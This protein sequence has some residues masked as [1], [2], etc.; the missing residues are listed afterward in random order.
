MYSSCLNLPFPDQFAPESSSPW[1][2]RPSCQ[3][4]ISASWTDSTLCFTRYPLSKLFPRRSPL[5]LFLQD[6]ITVD[7]IYYSL[8]SL[9]QTFFLF[10]AGLGWMLAM[11]GMYIGGAA[12]YA[13][14]IPE[15]WF[16]GKCDIWVRISVLYAENG[17]L[18]SYF[19]IH[20][21]LL[22]ETCFAPN[23]GSNGVL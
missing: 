11:G 14:R 10:Q 1:D 9:R 22:F 13:I 20:Y 21:G 5:F 3:Q 8:P 2:C 15:R 18:G 17:R 6:P 4:F 7:S 16:P 12:I 19:F 23:Y